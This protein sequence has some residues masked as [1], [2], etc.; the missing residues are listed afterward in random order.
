VETRSGRG[1]QGYLEAR[2][3]AMMGMKTK[4]IVFAARRQAEAS[5]PQVPFF[6]RPMFSRVRAPW[7]AGKVDWAICALCA[8]EKHRRANNCR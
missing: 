3:P 4:D 1:T 7:F 8:L 6:I 2:Q 5:V